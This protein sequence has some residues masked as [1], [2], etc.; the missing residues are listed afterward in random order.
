MKKPQII[1][2]ISGPKHFTLDNHSSISTSVLLF[3]LHLALNFIHIRYS[4]QKNV[5]AKTGSC[6]A[7]EGESECGGEGASCSYAGGQENPVCECPE[8]YVGNGYEDCEGRPPFI[9]VHLDKTSTKF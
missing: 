2:Q 4:L 9:E 3:L 7:G 6:G 1:P 8:G 5:S